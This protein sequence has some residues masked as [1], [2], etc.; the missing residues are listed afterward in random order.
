MKILPSYKLDLN[1]MK[2]SNLFPSTGNYLGCFED[3]DSD[4]HLNDAQDSS[5]GDTIDNCLTYCKS[6][7]L[8]TCNLCKYFL[9]IILIKFICFLVQ[10]VKQVKTFTFINGSI[11][12]KCPFSRFILNFDSSE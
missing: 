9:L 8:L 5:K 4:L 1:S 2:M 11:S 3:N 6:Q 7:V 10:H 12:L